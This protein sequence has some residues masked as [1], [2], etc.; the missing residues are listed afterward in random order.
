MCFIGYRFLSFA[1]YM[2]TNLSSTHGQ[3][4]LDKKKKKQVSNSAIKTIS[5]KGTQSDLRRN[6]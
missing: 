3:K 4:R 2:S 6:K 5:T 1:K